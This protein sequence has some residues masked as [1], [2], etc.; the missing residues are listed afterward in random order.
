MK[1]VTRKLA[2]VTLAVFCALC[3]FFCGS[4][5]AQTPFYQGKTITL[6]VGSG[7]GGMGDLRAKALASGLTR[8]I[9]GSPTI[10]FQY[11]PGAGGRKATNHIYNT[12]KPDG[13]TLLR[14]SSSI[15]PY[16]VLGE[17]GV[18]YDIDKFHYLGATEHQLYYMFITRKG[19]GLNN[20]EKLRTTPSVRIGSS[21]VGHTGYLQSRALAYW[22]DLKDPKIVPGYEGNDLDVAMANNEVDGR[23]ASTGTVSQNE[24]LSKGLADFHVA[25]EVPRGYKDP[26]FA[27]LRLP[28]LRSFAKSEKERK[29][30]AMMEGFRVVG[31]ILLAPPGTP[32]D[33][34]DI[35]KEAVRKT[36]SDPVFASE[37]KKLTGRDDPT[38]LMPEEQ[39]KIVREITRDPEII[40]LFKK[41]AGT[42]PLPPR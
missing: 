27:R 39:A 35:L 19:A 16:A 9:P 6:L 23:I 36:N 1:P 28:E 17:S 24:L 12:V 26:R 38:P 4:A 14:V 8:N 20:L 41:F 10:V 11:M 5:V 13:L 33:R 40:E 18:Q 3:L 30:L 34:L 32:K 7:P 15:V 37:Y 2:H 21:P 29:L 25:I 42:A 31:T 22:L